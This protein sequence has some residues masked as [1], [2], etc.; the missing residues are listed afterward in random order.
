MRVHP[1]AA[2]AIAT[3]VACGDAARRAAQ[4]QDPHRG[5]RDFLVA[6]KRI[7][8]ELLTLTNPEIPPPD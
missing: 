6:A 4:L 8:R 3:I 5:L 1:I 2:V 7:E